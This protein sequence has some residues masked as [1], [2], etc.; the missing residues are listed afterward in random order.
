MAKKLY[1][2]QNDRMLA[3]VS[4]GLAAYL[5][6]DTTIIRLIF[7]VLALPGFLSGILIYLVMWVIVPEEPIGADTKLDRKEI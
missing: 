4:G 2:S 5:N 7:I 6:I 1:R 3:G